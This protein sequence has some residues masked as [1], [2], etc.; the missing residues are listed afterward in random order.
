L[1]SSLED[2]TQNQSLL[3][4]SAAAVFAAAQI[5]HHD[6][7][8]LTS[9][10]NGINLHEKE[11]I[12]PH[13]EEYNLHFPIGLYLAETVA[14]TSYH[15]HFSCERHVF[16]GQ[17]ALFNSSTDTGTNRRSSDDVNAT[18]S[19]LTSFINVLPSVVRH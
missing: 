18:A 5:V 1:Q 14:G 9:E 16:G 3:S 12:N 2:D 6:R 19:K 11:K 8:A 15:D 4:T 13:L 17:S 7:G 10:F